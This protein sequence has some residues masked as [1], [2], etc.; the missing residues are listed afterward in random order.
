MLDS[1]I[2]NQMKIRILT[3]LLLV[4]S[5]AAIAGPAAAQQD[6]P[7]ITSPVAGDAVQGIVTVMGTSGLPGFVFMDLAFAYDS[8]PTNTWFRIATSDQPVSNGPL[9]IW[10][11]TGITDGVYSLRLRVTLT[12]GSHREALVT[13]FRVRNYTPIETATPVETPT[14]TPEL[15]EPTPAATATPTSTPF[16][17]PTLLP[18]N[19]AVVTTGDVKNSLIYGALTAI[20][21]FSIVGVTARFRRRNL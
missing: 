6:E 13:G 17:T 3:I 21:I 9:G 5:C 7:S 11:T 16:H 8:N 18:T 10:D 1:R 20:V 19:P 2:A 14:P 4:L 15:V 12:D